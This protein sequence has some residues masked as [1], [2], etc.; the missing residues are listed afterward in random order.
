MDGGTQRV[1]DRTK[2]SGSTTA[3]NA[4]ATFTAPGNGILRVGVHFPSAGQIYFTEDGDDV[5]LGSVL[6][7]TAKIL[8]WVCTEDLV[9]VLKSDTNQAAGAIFVV[10][11]VKE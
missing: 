10:D 6:G 8:E 3:G 7:N 5:Y 9:Y 2:T 11:F 4:F 1:A